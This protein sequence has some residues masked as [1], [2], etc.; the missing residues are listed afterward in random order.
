MRGKGISISVS[1]LREVDANLGQLSKATARNVLR[2]VLKKAGQPMADTA[3]ALAPDDPRTDAPDLHRSIIVST[4]LKN[5]VGKAEF[6]EV[7]QSGGTRAEAAQAMRD[8][9]RA[10]GGGSFAEMYVGPEASIFYAHLVEFGSVNNRPQPFMRPAYDQEK[11][12]VLDII[13]AELGGEIDKAVKRMLK[14]QAKKAAG[15]K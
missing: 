3:A 9:R 5:E 8:A 7:M 12:A 11:G 14:R 4:K 10:A 15:G 2:R 6:A 1:G 13:K